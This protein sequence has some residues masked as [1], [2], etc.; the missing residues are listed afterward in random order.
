MK[1]HELKCWP[2]YFKFI[3]TG[4]KTFEYRK[5]DRGFSVGDTLWL[6]EY[7]PD[8]EEYTGR[9]IRVLVSAV[10]TGLPGLPEGYC[11]MQI[12]ILEVW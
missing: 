4:Q 6:K 2:E 11:I 10:Y 7:K 9:H 1:D 12:K 5:D 8:L 3:L